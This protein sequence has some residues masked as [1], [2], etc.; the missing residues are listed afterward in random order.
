MRVPA[1]MIFGLLL[2]ILIM[3]LTTIMVVRSRILSSAELAL[4]AALVGGVNQGDIL[5]GRVFID[6]VAGFELARSYFKRNMSL[7]ENL[8]NNFL[9]KTVFRI[10]ISQR[11]DKPKAVAEIST[12]ITAISTKVLGLEGVPITVR[13]TRY[14]VSKYK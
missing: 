14:W 4:D 8:E 3:D 10:D 13:G 5:V 6:E 11:E 1:W 12:V 9:K 2:A 7:N